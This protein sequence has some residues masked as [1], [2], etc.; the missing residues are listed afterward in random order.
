MADIQN[1]SFETP[2]TDYG[3]AEHWD[4]A[5][6][7]TGEDCGQFWNG[8][9]YVPFE[10]FEG[11]DDSHLGALAFL[12]S[13]FSLGLFNGGVVGEENFETGWASPL[14]GPPFNH[15]GE[16]EFVLANFSIGQFDAANEDHEDFEEEWNDNET[17]VANWAAATSVVGQF[18]AA[19]DDHEDFEEEWLDNENSV[20]DFDA[21]SSTVG[22]FD[23]AAQA[24]EDFENLWTTTLP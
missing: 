10:G 6:S 23:G 17:S 7:N 3:Q 21:G 13:N 22:M 15:Q 24:Y 1:A 11:F 20:A 19:L 9:R 18:D 16:L 8:E 2:D 4:E 12:V 5:Y 14:I